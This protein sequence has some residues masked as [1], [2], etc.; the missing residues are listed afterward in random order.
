LSALAIPAA[1][2]AATAT[3]PAYAAIERHRTFAR[4][5]H[6]E[7]QAKAVQEALA[8]PISKYVEPDG[9]GIPDD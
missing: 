3:N 4:I 2:V 1:G 6:K 7:T 5:A 8:S 9:D